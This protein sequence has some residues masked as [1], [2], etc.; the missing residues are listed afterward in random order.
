MS[1]AEQGDDD[2]VDSES[3]DPDA[4]MMAELSQRVEELRDLEELRQRF[5]RMP[6][7]WVLVFD[8]DSDDE[9]VYSVELP[10][11][12]EHVVV[13][14]EDEDEVRCSLGGGHVLSA[15]PLEPLA[16]AAGAATHPRPRLARRG[17]MRRL[18]T[19]L[20]RSTTHPHQSKRSTSP[21]SSS[22]HARPNS[23]LRW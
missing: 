10:Q 3:C 16:P 2:R 23:A 8:P 9:A 7:A 11:H 19:R 14:F 4:P 6:H 12:A 22:R 5:E 17:R 15:E 13:A 20:S 1:T 18:W 21:R